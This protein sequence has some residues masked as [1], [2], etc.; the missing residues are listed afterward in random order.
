MTSTGLEKT[1]QGHYVGVVLV[2]GEGTAHIVI[3]HV[4]LLIGVSDPEA[5]DP[6]EEPLK[7]RSAIQ[8]WFC[9]LL[10]PVIDT[11]D[12]KTPRL[13]TEC[14]VEDGRCIPDI[15]AELRLRVRL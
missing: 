4:D 1:V 13:G 5:V 14:A 2:M 11:I 12:T 3:T 15:G 10:C 6:V 9:Q 8:R 7:C